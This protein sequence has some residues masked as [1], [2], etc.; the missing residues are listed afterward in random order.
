[1]TRVVKGYHG[2]SPVLHVT[3]GIHGEPFASLGVYQLGILGQ[4][5]GVSQWIACHIHDTPLRRQGNI[6]V[7]GDDYD[8]YGNI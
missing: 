5:R 2:G 7:H 4:F 8:R 6:G 3:D 1:V